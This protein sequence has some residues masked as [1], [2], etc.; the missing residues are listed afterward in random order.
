[1]KHYWAWYKQLIAKGYS[2]VYSLE[3]AWYNSRRFNLD[4]TKR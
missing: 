1:M 3:Y 4:G 2:R